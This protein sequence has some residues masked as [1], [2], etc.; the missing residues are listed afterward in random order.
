MQ[1]DYALNWPVIDIDEQLV[2]KEISKWVNK[3][4]LP[5]KMRL[6]TTGRSVAA[7][8]SYISYVLGS[9]LNGVIIRV[10]S[11]EKQ[12]VRAKLRS[13]HGPIYDIKF[14]GSDD[15]R[16]GCVMQRGVVVWE[17]LPSPAGSVDLGSAVVF[18]HEFDS[19]LGSAAAMFWHPLSSSTLIT[20]HESG[21]LAVWDWDKHTDAPH[22]TLHGEHTALCQDASFSPGGDFVASAGTDGQLVV[23]DMSNGSV[24]RKWQPHGGSAVRSVIW[25]NNT[26]Q[27][28]STREVGLMITGAGRNSEIKL[29]STSSW[30]CLQTVNLN[31]PEGALVC[32]HASL[33]PSASFLFLANMALGSMYVLHL[34]PPQYTEDG[35]PDTRRCHFDHIRE[36]DTQWRIS[37]LLC[38]SSE[39]ISGADE[40]NQGS[41]ACSMR[42][43]LYCA[44]TNSVNM[45]EMDSEECFP[46]IT[47]Q[48]LEVAESAATGQSFCG[49]Q[50][51]ASE[52]QP[53]EQTEAVLPQPTSTHDTAVESLQDASQEE[54]SSSTSST[55]GHDEAPAPCDAGPQP[56]QT[57]GAEPS[58]AMQQ[59][60]A[61]EQQQTPKKKPVAPKQPTMAAGPSPGP[62]FAMKR[63]ATTVHKP[64]A[65]APLE[66]PANVTAVPA[67][68][69]V[70]VAA[71][72]PA[73]A[74]VPV[75]PQMTTPDIPK[76]KI[77][78]A[79]PPPKQEVAA[80]VAAPAV[81]GSVSEAALAS[82]LDKLKGHTDKVIARLEK[83]QQEREK[84][85]I[86]AIQAS[87]TASVQAEVSNQ[88][89][90]VM[91]P[92][93][94]QGVE[95]A[96]AR[97]LPLALEA[98]LSQQLPS[99]VSSQLNEAVVQG[100]AGPAVREA[101]KGCFVQQLIPSFENA[102]QGMF[103]QINNTFLT[104]LQD[105]VAT[106]LQA[107]FDGLRS[108]LATQLS[109]T[110]QNSTAAA[111]E[112][113]AQ[114][115]P[116]E[117]IAQLLEQNKVVDALSFALSQGDVE[118]VMQV[119]RDGESDVFEE[120]PCNVPQQVL[121]SLIQQLGYDL[122]SELEIK[123][124]WLQAA[125][126]VLDHSDNL[127]KTLL[128]SLLEELTAS[129]EASF[130]IHSVRSD[131][132]HNSI[133]L[134]LRL[135]SSINR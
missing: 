20:A 67:T 29:W 44:H 133:K 132:S 40:G 46:G 21:L 49:D 12:D 96:V 52:P 101:F 129:L 81:D 87:L 58:T 50:E 105:Q 42:I 36:F 131:P 45:V 10:I 19:S 3:G 122:E 69:P 77:N 135:V 41:D 53:Q 9:T 39:M 90:Q 5:E 15:S 70:P 59:P 37:S 126:L 76:P 1:A 97:V 110:A 84:K 35:A 127:T 86:S 95:Q 62:G 91:L 48:Q 32:N 80:P 54:T 57:G 114:P 16:L 117:H 100:L 73:P 43:R 6:Y 38:A 31:A 2:T 7:N 79:K 102:V 128:P 113:A 82:L 68:Q 34:R 27:E 93:C 8:D 112:A 74:P 30:H 13:D 111:P 115:T 25:C 4:G 75:P 83:Q 26:Q 24:V 118:C 98:Q 14:C 92:A 119:C 89:M 28:A 108:E 64:P 33:D 106:P 130:R 99:V 11:L 23:W 120:R 72:V 124:E 18:S 121:C 85:L 71:P 61:A 103:K 22:A 78:G 60:A 66:M 88:V 65:P 47:Q 125:L 17:L 56:A 51:T 55:T 63:Q 94:T 123:M 107:Q 116:T 134:M 104:G 109:H